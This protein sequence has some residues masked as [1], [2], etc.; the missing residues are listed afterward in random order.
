MREE[1]GRRRTLRGL[2]PVDGRLRG[3]KGWS[4]ETRERDV[5]LA[6]RVEV[7]VCL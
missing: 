7:N 3:G 4:S 6:A 1:G 5:A 2:Q